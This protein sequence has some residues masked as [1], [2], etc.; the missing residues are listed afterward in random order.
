M[1]IERINELLRSNIANIVSREIYLA[2]G[3]VT[4]TKVDTSPDLK[5]AKIYISVLPEKLTGTAL[6]QL[7]KNNALFSRQIAK[8]TRLRKVPKFKWLLDEGERRI[9]E[10]SR[11]MDDVDY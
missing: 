5:Y 4:I 6:K 11:I 8:T 9:V 10:V 7:R 3:L 1:I 2:N